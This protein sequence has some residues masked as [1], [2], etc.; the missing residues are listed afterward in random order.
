LFLFFILPFLFLVMYRYG[1]VQLFFSVLLGM[2][3]VDM[4]LCFLWASKFTQRMGCLIIA[5]PSFLGRRHGFMAATISHASTSGF[6]IQFFTRRSARAVPTKRFR[7]LVINNEACLF[8]SFLPS[9]VQYV[10]VRLSSHA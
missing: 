4:A 6:P 1:L 5:S 7:F 8:V 3:G 9:P 10:G 2:V